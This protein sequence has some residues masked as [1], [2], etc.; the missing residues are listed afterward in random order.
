MQKRANQKEGFGFAFNYSGCDLPTD[1][2][3]QFQKVVD[4][5]GTHG[6]CD[7]AFVLEMVLAGVGSAHPQSMEGA[8]LQPTAIALK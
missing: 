4:V 7:V 1:L 3:E 6:L 8:D 2:S 5:G